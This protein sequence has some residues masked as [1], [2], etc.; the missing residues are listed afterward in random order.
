[1]WTDFLRSWNTCTSHLQYDTPQQSG[2]QHQMVPS[3]RLVPILPLL[4]PTRCLLQINPSLKISQMVSVVYTYCCAPYTR[5]YCTRYHL[6]YDKIQPQCIRTHRQAV[7]L[8]C[9]TR[10]C[11]G[12]KFYCH[13]MSRAVYPARHRGRQSQRNNPR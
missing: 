6:W 3:R 9:L 11:A 8:L 10:C 4:A 12:L 5:L 13:V 2:C 7:S 1:M